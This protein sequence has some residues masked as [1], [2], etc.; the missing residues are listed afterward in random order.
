VHLT[1]ECFFDEV[2]AFESDKVGFASAGAQEGGA[3]FFD[4]GVLL[5]LYNS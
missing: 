2:E 1:A 4:P 3:E 5:T